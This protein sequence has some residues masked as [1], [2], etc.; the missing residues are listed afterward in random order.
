MYTATTFWK[1]WHTHVIKHHFLSPDL[2]QSH[3][4]TPSRLRLIIIAGFLTTIALTMFWLPGGQAMAD[5]VFFTQ[6]ARQSTFSWRV[7]NAGIDALRQK[8]MHP[9]RQTLKKG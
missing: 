8:R 4:L 6:P 2:A 9:S 3:W 1:W 7:F 5:E